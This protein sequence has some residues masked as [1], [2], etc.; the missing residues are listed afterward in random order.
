[1]KSY[2]CKRLVYVAVFAA[3]VVADADAQRTGRRRTTTPSL[4]I[5]QQHNQQQNNNNTQ[6]SGYN[7]YGNIP[8]VVDSS[9]MSDTCS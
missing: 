2:C 3:L 1:M 6:P 5:T 8:I 4:Q 9:G 7:P